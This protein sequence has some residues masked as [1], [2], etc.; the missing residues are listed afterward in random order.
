MGQKREKLIDGPPWYTTPDAV[1]L[2]K[3]ASHEI[4]Q[5]GIAI[6]GMPPTS[7]EGESKMTEKKQSK[8]DNK[9]CSSI[10]ETGDNCD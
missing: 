7:R 3:L 8:K 2:F 5:F 9:G 4:I 6:H 10:I 1:S